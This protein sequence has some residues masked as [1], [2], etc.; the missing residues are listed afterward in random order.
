ML[1]K[2]IKKINFRHAIT[3]KI[4]ATCITI[5]SGAASANTLV[6]ISGTVLAAPSCVINGNKIINVDFGNHINSLFVNGS[7]Y[8][9]D[10]DYDLECTNLSSSTMRLMLEGTGADFNNNA[11]LT[12]NPDLAISIKATGQVLAINRWFTFSFPTKP[13]LQAVLIKREGVNLTPG[14]FRASATLK[15]DYQ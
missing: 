11:L 1:N 9:R 6:N 5:T 12:N 3:L 4:F 10:I 13:E 8:V 14:Y 7:N 15:I 2:S